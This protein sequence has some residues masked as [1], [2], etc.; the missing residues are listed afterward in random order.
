MSD[1]RVDVLQAATK[2]RRLVEQADTPD[3]RE[4]ARCSLKR[5]FQQHPAL[6]QAIERRFPGRRPQQF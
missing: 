5:L 6:R 3:L 2:L 4:T 1:L